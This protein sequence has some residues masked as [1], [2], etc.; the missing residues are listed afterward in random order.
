MHG[1]AFLTDLKRELHRCWTPPF[2]APIVVSVNASL[3]LALWF[4]APPPL[5]DAVFTLHGDLA[6]PMILASW[7]YSDV[8]ATNVLGGDRTAAL[9]A[10]GD[11]AAL[12]R[13]LLVKNAAL[14]CFVSPVCMVGAVAIGAL[15]ASGTQLASDNGHLNGSAWLLTLVAVAWIAVAPIG[16]LGVAAWVGVWWPYHPISLRTRFDHR[17]PYRRMI[18]RWLFVILVPYGVVPAL[19]V[20]VVMPSLLAWKLL[21]RNGL[22]S[23]LEWDEFAVGTLLAAVT[24]VGMWRMGRRATVRMCERRAVELR[25]FLADPLNG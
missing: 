7:M 16:A 1:S 20:V 2:E 11:P 18:V 12:R 25:S 13:L 6:L 15:N 3:V 24:A 22:N 14:W 4:L 9:A 17:R 10:L 19:T 23:A 21:A 8:P 5:L